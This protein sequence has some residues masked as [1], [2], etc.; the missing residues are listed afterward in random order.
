[1]HLCHL[2]PNDL[3]L[4]RFSPI[5]ETRPLAIE[6][7]SRERKTSSAEEESV[8]AAR[9]VLQQQEAS[10]MNILVVVIYSEEGRWWLKSDEGRGVYV[11]LFYLIPLLKSYYPV[12]L[13]FAIV[14]VT[15]LTAYDVQIPFALK[16]AEINKK[17][18]LLLRLRGDCIPNVCENACVVDGDLEGGFGLF[19]DEFEVL[20][21]VMIKAEDKPL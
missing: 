20:E 13:R 6:R 4:F 1:G 14:H 10:H 21:D 17:L 11:L 3:L 5:Q 7:E 2:T 8:T 12:D 19:D 16:V 9:G 18:R 15:Q